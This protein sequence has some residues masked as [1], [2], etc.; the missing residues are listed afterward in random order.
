MKKDSDV[1]LK[2]LERMFWVALVVFAVG[3]V[4]VLAPGGLHGAGPTSAGTY[5][6]TLDEI[7]DN[8]YNASA[9]AQPMFFVMS[10]KGLASAATISIPSNTLIEIV[11]VSYDMGA[12][13]PPAM[14]DQVTGTVNNEMTVINGTAGS[15]TDTSQAWGENVTSVPGDMIAHTFT[16]SSLGLNLP[17][18]AGDTEIAYFTAHTKGTFT[19]VCETPCGTGADGMGGAM[20]TPG[21]MLGQITVT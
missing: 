5:V 10:D 11:I 2:G 1:S 19:W 6:L 16:V 14:Y 4:Y 3:L 7:M 18:I 20:A 9:P 17:V 12:A 13:P 8:R 15:G 21:W